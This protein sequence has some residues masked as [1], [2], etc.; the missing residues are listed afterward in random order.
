M[1]FSVTLLYSSEYKD[2]VVLIL[3]FKRYLY[4]VIASDDSIFVSL[5][6]LVPV[7]SGWSSW[8]ECSHTCQGGYKYRTRR[9]QNG[10]NIDCSGVSREIK[11]CND[12]IV[13]N[14]WTECSKTCG[15]GVQFR[16]IGPRNRT[17]QRPCN[18]QP[19]HNESCIQG[20]N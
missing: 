3:E 19:C 1:I 18:T 14:K 11:P 5:C 16:I 2:N 7:W 13:C 20:K 4:G 12:D 15:T 8:S 17:E 6:I 10:A 9:C